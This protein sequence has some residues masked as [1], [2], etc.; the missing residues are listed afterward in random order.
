MTQSQLNVRVPRYLRQALRQHKL[1]EDEHM[2]QAVVNALQIYL[3]VQP[4]ETTQLNV[5]IP[6]SLHKRLRVR[7][8]ET[9]RPIK[10]IVAE[11]LRS[12]LDS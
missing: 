8:A 9:D 4:E 11:A 1:E 2:E 7:S 10:Q 12:R 3:D 6:E 5:E